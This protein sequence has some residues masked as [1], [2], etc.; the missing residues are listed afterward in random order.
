MIGVAY[1][2]QLILCCFAGLG[3]NR[4]RNMFV[5][6]LRGDGGKSVLRKP[7]L[8]NLQTIAINDIL[9]VLGRDC[10][11]SNE[12][13]EQKCNKQQTKDCQKSLSFYLYLS[14]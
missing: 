10:V 1:I 3:I 4:Q 12:A 8:R 5:R 7:C 11:L 2:D 9:V 14:K 13:K 6:K